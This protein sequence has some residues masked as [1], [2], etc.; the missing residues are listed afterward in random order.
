VALKRLDRA[1]DAIADLVEAVA[2]CSEQRLAPGG[3]YAR[4]ELAEAYAMAGRP[5]E[6]A[7]VAEEAL[8]AFDDLGEQEAASN[9]RF[10][11]AKQY[12]EIGDR[13]GAV[14]RYRELIEQLADNPAGRGQVG[15]EAAGLLYDMDHDAEAAEAFQAAAEALHEAG[16]LVGELRTLRRR[17]AAL[18]FADEP[19]AAAET[20]RLAGERFAALSGELAAEPNAIWQNGLTAYEQARI[21]MSRDRF[22][23]AVPV[24]RGVPSRLRGIGA[25]DDADRLDAMYGEALL[26]SG[27]AAVAEAHLRDLL[28]G[29]GPDAPGREL[30]EQIYQEAREAT[31]P[32]R[33]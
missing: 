17:L 9:A 4:W 33:S 2:L 29:L 28:A 6:A 25:V 32:D 16:D 12:R 8:L 20:F 14:S 26:R 5:V 31:R 24:L 13:A 30:A 18:H 7:E 22:A 21:L 10:L 15:E 3:A 11:L 27:E 23:E 19:E 1:G